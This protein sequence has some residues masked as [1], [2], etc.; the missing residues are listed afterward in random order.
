MFS[1]P[2]NF[3][4]EE[5][6]YVTIPALRR[7]A[8]ENNEGDLKTTVDRPQLIENLEKYAN[9]SVKKQE[10]VLDWLDHV[11][12]EGIKEVQVRWLDD[13]YQVNL[14]RDDA[15][16]ENILGPLLVDKNNCHLCGKYSNKLCL[17]RYEIVSDKTLGRRIRIYLGKLLSTF[18]KNKGSAQIP[19]PVFVEIF[20]DESLIVARSKSKSG[21]YQFM[22]NFVLEAATPTKAEKQMDLAVEFICDLFSIKTVSGYEA[23]ELFRNKLYLMLEKYTETPKEIGEMMD[24]KSVEI[25]RM[26]QN[27][28]NDICNLD[29]KYKED[30]ISNIQNIVEKYFS[31]SYPDKEIF[32]RDRD[33]YPLK[34]SATDEE[35]SKVEQIAAMETPLQSKAI[36]F[37]NKK[38]LQKSRTCDGVTF[39]FNRIKSLYFNKRFKVS[40]NVNKKF[41][42]FKFVEYTMEEDIIDVLFSFI[43]TDGFDK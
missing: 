5:E 42:T 17:Y 8:K 4:D 2:H 1:I 16:I 33:A 11:L 12:V 20:L 23:V 15:Y 3:A 30:V 31:I 21:L 35:E 26:V 38:M 25:D 28:M 6:K 27:L 36:F 7:F 32:I 9:Q 34:L 24:E 40:I 39:S 13:S 43:G 41:C 14:M 10:E 29:I 22:E 18:D 37:D 19:Y